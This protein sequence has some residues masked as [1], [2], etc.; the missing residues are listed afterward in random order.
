MEW[1][2]RKSSEYIYDQSFLSLVLN[3][4]PLYLP[5]EILESLNFNQERF[6]KLDLNAPKIVVTAGGL[7]QSSKLGIMMRKW[8][9][10]GTKLVTQQHGGGYGLDRNMT[11]EEYEKEIQTI[12]VFGKE[13]I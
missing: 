9:K 2:L 12:S 1:R 5:V 6:L 10:N 11:L 13:K 3:L 7:A 4:L 8:R